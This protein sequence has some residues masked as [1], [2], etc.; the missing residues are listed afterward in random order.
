ML[1]FNN[2]K[3][4]FKRITPTKTLAF[5]TASDENR[6]K[7]QEQFAKKGRG[8]LEIQVEV[9]DVDGVLTAI[10]SFTWF[11]QKI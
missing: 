11:I 2:D 6:V 7:F 9:K 10:S 3:W 8:S 4:I 1:S 5:A